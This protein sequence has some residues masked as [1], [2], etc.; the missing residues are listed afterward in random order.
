MLVPDADFV[1][2]PLSDDTIP[3]PGAMMSVNAL[4]SVKAATLS[5]LSVAPTEITLRRQAGAPIDVP[6]PLLPDEAKATTPRDRSVLIAEAPAMVHDVLL[7]IA[8]T[9]K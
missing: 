2:L 1:L 3:T 9:E 4:L 7:S 5:A 8:R 6:V